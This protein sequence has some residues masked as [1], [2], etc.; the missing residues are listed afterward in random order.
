MPRVLYP[1]QQPGSAKIS[2]ARPEENRENYKDNENRKSDAE[3]VPLDLRAGQR[4]PQF[5]AW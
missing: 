5:A 3:P 1:Q 2:E 4:L